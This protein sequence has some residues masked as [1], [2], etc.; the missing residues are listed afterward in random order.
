MAL[1]TVAEVRAYGG[2]DHAN[3]A[4]EFRYTDE[5]QLDDEVQKCIAW[6]VNWLT[7]R[8]DA[9]YYTGTAGFA[10]D[11]LFR[12][13]E[14]DLALYR[15]LP[16]LKIRKVLGTHAPL[17]QETSDRFEALIDT[18]I[19]RHVEMAIEPFATVDTTDNPFALPALVAIE[20]IDRD[21]LVAWPEQLQ[22]EIDNATGLVGTY[23]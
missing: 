13:A 1:T 16:R 3:D 10:N 14:E 7:A 9:A 15:L 17:D 22:A 23:E 12:G 21:D 8:V 6:A 2:I 20:P 5:A 18:E 19:P 11:D 4:F